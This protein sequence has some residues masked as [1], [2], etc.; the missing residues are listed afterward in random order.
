MGNNKLSYDWE[1]TKTNSVNCYMF[2]EAELNN[3]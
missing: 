3:S 1:D 2:K